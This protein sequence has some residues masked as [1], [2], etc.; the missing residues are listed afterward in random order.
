MFST[1][2]CNKHLCPGGRREP[3]GLF[4]LSPA[5]FLNQC[6]FAV[7]DTS[8]TNRVIQVAENEFVCSPNAGCTV[9]ARSLYAAG[10]KEA[11]AVA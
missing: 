10:R 11:A 9:K 1:V 7:S 3:R 8:E 2:L 6:A 4:F 5:A